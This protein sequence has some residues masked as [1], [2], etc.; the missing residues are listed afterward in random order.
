MDRRSTSGES[1]LKLF[2]RIRQGAGERRSFRE[3]RAS[4]RV[5]AGFPVEG[6]GGQP[7]VTHDLST[8]GLSIDGG[9]P[10]PKGAKLT[11]KLFLP[12]D[13]KTPLV[14]E[15]EVLGSRTSAGG[16]RMR[17]LKPPLDAIRRIHLLVK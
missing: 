10:L 13:P 14:L 8:F 2:E 3:R 4:P 6:T 11:V 7:L 5:N 16:T 1:M 15:A 9:E 12:D 17:F